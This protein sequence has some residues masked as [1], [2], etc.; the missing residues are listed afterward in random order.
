MR[1]VDLDSINNV[2][3]NLMGLRHGVRSVIVFIVPL[4]AFLF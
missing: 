3:T 1:V 4:Y 2:A